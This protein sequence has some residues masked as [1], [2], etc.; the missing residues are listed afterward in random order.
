MVLAM[1]KM[2]F[3][4]GNIYLGVG[5]T[6]SFAIRYIVVHYNRNRLKS[7]SRDEFEMVNPQWGIAMELGANILLGSGFVNIALLSQFNI[8]NVANTSHFTSVHS[9]S[10]LVVFIGYGLYLGLGP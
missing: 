1:G 4:W 9:S 2:P 8:T 7:L 5:P 10:P 3:K 6:N